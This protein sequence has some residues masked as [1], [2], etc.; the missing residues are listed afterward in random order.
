VVPA[1]LTP[2]RGLTPAEQELALGAARA[3]G[4]P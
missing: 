1:S 2:L 4:F 3:V